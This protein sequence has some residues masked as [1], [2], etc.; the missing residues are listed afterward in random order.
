MFLREEIEFGSDFLQRDVLES[1]DLDYDGSQED[2]GYQNGYY[3]Q[4]N[5]TGRGQGVE[6]ECAFG[7]LRSQR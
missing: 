4:R 6:T 5:S 7:E 1:K 2:R 3:L